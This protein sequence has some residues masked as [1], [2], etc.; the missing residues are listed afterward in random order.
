MDNIIGTF[1]EGGVF[2][3]LILGISL[4]G[5]GLTI[6]KSYLYWI[7][8]RI[9]EEELTKAIVKQVEANNYSRAIQYCN[10]RVH[11]LTTILKSGL[12]RANKAEKDIRRAIEVT[13]SE[14]IPKFRRGVPALP[15]LSNISTMLGLLGTIR[16]LIIAFAGM[17]GGDAVKRQDALSTGIALAFS[18]TF[19]AL[20]VAVSL[21]FFYVILNSKQNKMMAKME[22]AT[23]TIVDA[24][25]EKNKKL[26]AQQQRAS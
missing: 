26:A 23:N 25:V 1:H 9:S 21:V 24:I 10:G 12:I 15:H 20:A 2:M 4:F 14:V 17:A 16:G 8:Y 18:A 19:F 3:Y 6:N 13:A 22:H 5:I 7:K 11:P